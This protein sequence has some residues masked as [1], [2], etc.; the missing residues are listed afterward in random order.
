MGDS[1]SDTLAD[2]GRL[3]KTYRELQERR[4]DHELLELAEL[5]EDGRGIT[6]SPDWNERF[7]EDGDQHIIYSYWRYTSRMEVALGRRKEPWPECVSN[8]AS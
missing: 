3:I 6:F 7:I 8:L 4:P 5:H 1:L 2:L